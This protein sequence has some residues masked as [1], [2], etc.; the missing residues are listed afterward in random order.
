MRG[1]SAV[2]TPVGN[3]YP[4]E[5]KDPRLHG[6]CGAL[7]GG[8]TAKHHAARGDACPGLLIPAK[9][10]LIEVQPPVGPSQRDRGKRSVLDNY[11]VT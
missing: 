3:Q 11:Y 5:L 1:L 10:P 7:T 8:P 6:R 4:A 2:I 9:L